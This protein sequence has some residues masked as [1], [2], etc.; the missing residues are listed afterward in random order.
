MTRGKNALRRAA[1][2]G[3]FAMLAGLAGCSTDTPPAPQT[4]DPVTQ[5]NFDL[6]KCQQLEANLY[7]CPAI[8]KP[9]C[10]PQF[11]RSD[12]SCVRIGDK[13]SVFVTRQGM[14]Q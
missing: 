5:A 6:S 14:P 9:L 3:V 4:G 7:K 11:N 1:L 10:T 13:G 12:I 2:V 8:D